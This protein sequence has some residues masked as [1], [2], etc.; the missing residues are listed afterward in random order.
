MSIMYGTHK[1]RWIQEEISELSVAHA[2]G[3]LGDRES[4]ERYAKQHERSAESVMLKLIELKLER[5]PE[6][7]IDLSPASDQALLDEVRR[8]GLHD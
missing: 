3:E 4:I 7:V 8:R 1:T 6:K 2:K 5:P